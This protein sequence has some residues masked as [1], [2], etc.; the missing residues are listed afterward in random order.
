MLSENLTDE[1]FRVINAPDNTETL[2]CNQCVTALASSKMKLVKAIGE[3]TGIL[4]LLWHYSN[5]D[6]H[7]VIFQSEHRKWNIQNFIDITGHIK[8][9]ILLMHAFLRC[10]DVS[11]IYVIDRITKFPHKLNDICFEVAPLFYNFI[12]STSDNKKQVKSFCL[13]CIIS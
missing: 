4:G 10:D 13:A 5:K 9:I 7:V 8:E 3:D 2:I 1:G 12:S 11:R 6:L